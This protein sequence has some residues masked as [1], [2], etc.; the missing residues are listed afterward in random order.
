MF[1]LIIFCLIVSVSCY[2]RYNFTIQCP[3]CIGSFQNNT[4]VGPFPAGLLKMIIIVNVT[5]VDI[6]EA[7]G[8]ISAFIIPSFPA[9]ETGYVMNIISN[10]THFFNGNNTLSCSGDIN[11]GYGC[12]SGSG[13]CTYNTGGNTQYSG[14][15]CSKNGYAGYT[16]MLNNTCT[17]YAPNSDT[18][19][20]ELNTKTQINSNCYKTN[21]IQKDI[22][23]TYLPTIGVHMY[24]QTINLNRNNIVFTASYLIDTLN[25]S[26]FYIDFYTLLSYNNMLN[27]EVNLNLDYAIKYNAVL[28]G[29]SLKNL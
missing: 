9:L 10:D 25:Y 1:K 20:F 2:E 14:V 24:T 16:M 15:R 12:V 7:S 11:Y 8:F 21:I 6:Y 27:Y 4:V 13:G 5:T 26:Q 23:T 3:Q 22:S 18:Q 28:F 17:Q 29:T 19:V